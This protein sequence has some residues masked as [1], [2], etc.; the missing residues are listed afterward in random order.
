[1]FKL[2]DILIIFAVLAMILGS[3]SAYFFFTKSVKKH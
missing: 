3:A 1:M 2:G